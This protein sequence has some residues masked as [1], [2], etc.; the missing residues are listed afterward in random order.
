MR[1]PPSLKPTIQSA[2]V[3]SNRPFRQSPNSEDPCSLGAPKMFDMEPSP[4]LFGLMQ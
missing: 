2:S 3:T 1:K 4:S